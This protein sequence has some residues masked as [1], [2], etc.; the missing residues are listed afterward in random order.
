[1]FFS[2]L[3]SAPVTRLTAIATLLI[4]PIL[5]NPAVADEHSWSLQT[6]AGETVNFPDKRE[7]PALLLFWASWCPYCK[8]LMPEVQSIAD[9]YDGE[10]AVYAINFRDDEDPQAYMD[11]YG[12]T[13]T[14]L[15]K[16]GDVADLYDIWA[17]PGVLIFDADNQQVFNLYELVGQYE[18]ANGAI[19][20]ELSN[21]QK[22]ARLAPWWGEQIEAALADLND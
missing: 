1:M 8:A 5:C 22:A 18:E 16:G 4:S 21:S 11:K 14:N 3:L 17:T 13:F 9:N 19:P 7:G 20:E 2:T 6:P 10:L 12:Y 15:V